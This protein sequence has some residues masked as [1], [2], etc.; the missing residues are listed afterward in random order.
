MPP[1]SASRCRC[2]R[3]RD[4]GA[5][6]QRAGERVLRHSARDARASAR[7]AQR[8]RASV[9]PSRGSVGAS[10]DLAPL[11]HLA[12][13]DRR[14]VRDGR[15][16]ATRPVPGAEALA[17]PGFAPITLE[18]KEGLA[19]ING[20]QPSTAVAALA[21]AGAERLARAA[22]IAVALSIDAL[23]GSVHPFE[24][25]IHA[26]A[27]ACGPAALGGQRPASARRAARSTSRTRTAAACR[28]PTRCAARRRCT[29]RRA[30]RSISSADADHRGQR[31]DRQPDGVRRRRRD[32]VGGNFHG[33][34]V[35][36]AADLLAI[37]A[38]QFAT[39]SE[40]RSDRLV[41]PGAQRAAGVPDAEQRA[42]V[43]LHDGAGDG[44]GA[45]VGDQD[46]RAHPASVD[47]IP[48]SAN[49]EDHVSMSMGAAL[50][51]ERAVALATRVVAIEILCACQALDL[52][53]RSR[54]RRR[55]SACTRA[56]AIGRADARRRSSAGAGHRARSPR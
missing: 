22:D 2:A 33:A 26:A 29:A 40:R 42:A 51:A 53:A 37:A 5:A 45:G 1:A 44:R 27:A 31:R 6:R 35:A 9:V 32:R 20:T 4:D 56:C 8:R 11:A 48:T 28:T 52:L 49:R 36:I 55:C 10:G 19:L 30:T 21:L 46:A 47:T 7:A 38:A 23:R 50:K 17:P 15:R 13:A 34:P 18:A 24:A 14:R 12:R 41:N 43:G 54:R 3:A 25:R 39:I 16:S